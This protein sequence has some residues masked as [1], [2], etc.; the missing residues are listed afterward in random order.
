[1]VRIETYQKLYNT[2]NLNIKTATSLVTSIK[3]NT[4]KLPGFKSPTIDKIAKIAMNNPPDI[5]MKK[6][7]HQ[8]DMLYTDINNA[9]NASAKEY[10]FKYLNMIPENI[11]SKYYFSDD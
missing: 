8:L 6:W 7:N 9:V 2:N 3:K 1:M 10:F 11:R 5:K 4:G